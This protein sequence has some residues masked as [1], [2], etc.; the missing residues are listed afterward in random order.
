LKRKGKQLNFRIE[1]FERDMS[2]WQFMDSQEERD[3]NRINYM[4][5]HYGTG[6]KN[7][8]GAAY[9][10]INLAYDQSGEGQRLA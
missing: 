4:Q 2:R 3:K 9:N 10:V 6:K 1:K 7:K 8:G 5:E